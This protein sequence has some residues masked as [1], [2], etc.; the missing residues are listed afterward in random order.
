MAVLRSA[1]LFSE[2]GDREAAALVK[3]MGER[4][5]PAGTEVLTQGEIGAGFFVVSSGAVDVVVDGTRLH[6]LGPGDHFGDFALIA[7]SARTATV[8][9][10][11]D[12]ECFTLTSWDFRRLVETNPTV[13]WRVMAA[14]AARLL[15]A[16]GEP[17]TPRTPPNP[18]D[19]QMKSRGP[20]LTLVAV[21]SLALV[22]L[23]ING[24]SEP[25]PAP[26]PAAASAPAVPE[27]P[28]TAAPAP[29]PVAPPAPAFP[30]QVAFAGRTSGNEL[31]VAIAVQDGR[32]VAYVC[33]G[34]QIEAWLEGTVDGS[35][36]TLTGDDG[37][38]VAGELDGD[39]VLGQVTVGE[40]RWPFAAAT[41]AA[42]AGTYRGEV[43]VNGVLKRMGWNVLPDGTVTGLASD[44]T[45]APPLD[46]ASR[47]ATLGGVPVA[48]TPVT[49]TDDV[50]G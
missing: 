49:G 47:S 1:P 10:V 38:T 14:M 42:P 4:R 48:V 43:S 5:F 36:L 44:G 29:E 46:P 30:A 35:T 37:A 28:P 22:L 39:S 8:V 40:R 12:V 6:S 31:T 41:A 21:V 3:V 19:E 2:L 26:V 27:P 7:G 15:G 23:G 34:E 50:T 25:A 32:A 24:A 33:D 13:S 16:P 9:A 45:P 17:V 18:G 11:T 20:A